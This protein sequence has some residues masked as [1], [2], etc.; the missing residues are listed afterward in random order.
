MCKSEKIG[1]FYNS[2]TETFQGVRPTRRSD[3]LPVNHAPI[4]VVATHNGCKV[5]PHNIQFM[6]LLLVATLILF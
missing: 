5:V 2:T 6:H 4:T 1:D 3:I